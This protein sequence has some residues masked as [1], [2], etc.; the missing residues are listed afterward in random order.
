MRILFDIYRCESRIILAL[1]NTLCLCISQQSYLEKELQ[2]E[3]NYEGSQTSEHKY[4]EQYAI[5]VN[6]QAKELYSIYIS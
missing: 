2:Q 1:A 3:V 6:F 4:S 5:L